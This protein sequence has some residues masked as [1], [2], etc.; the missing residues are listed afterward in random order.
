MRRELAAISTR[1]RDA[2]CCVWTYLGHVPSYPGVVW[3]FTVGSLGWG[4][5]EPRR[6]PPPELRFYTHAVHRAAFQLP[7]YLRAAID[8][9][10]DD[11]P[12]IAGPILG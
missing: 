11:A 2:F 7:T 10:P 6:D 4:A 9:G 1:M 12:A 8:V 5:T 3:S